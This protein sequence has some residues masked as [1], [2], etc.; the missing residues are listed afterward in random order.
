MDIASD[1]Q[2]SDIVL[3]DIRGLA[4]FADYFVICTAINSRH[5]QAL[6]EELDVTCKRQGIRMLRAEGTPDSGWILMDFGDVLVHLFSSEAR[7]LY[8][9]E[10]LWGRATAV[11]RL[12]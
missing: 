12:Q 6:R 1:H 3:L 2:A 7:E 11:V 10:Q 8:A 5:L 9:L 4:S